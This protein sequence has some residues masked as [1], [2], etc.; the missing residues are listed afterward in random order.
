MISNIKSKVYGNHS[1]T[2]EI[3]P[4]LYGLNGNLFLIQIKITKVFHG[5]LDEQSFDIFANKI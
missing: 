4:E 3:L 2:E 1:L 5:Y